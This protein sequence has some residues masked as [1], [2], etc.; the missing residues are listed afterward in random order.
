M[1]ILTRQVDQS[2][3]IYYKGVLIATV[4]LTANKGK[5]IDLG[6]DTPPE[7]HMDVDVWR[8][9]LVEANGG[10]PPPRP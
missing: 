9:E 6:F 7:L 4:T 1:L 5:K 10:H 3:N 8:T 2:V